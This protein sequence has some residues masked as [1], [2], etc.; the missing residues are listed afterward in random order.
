MSG[1]KRLMRQPD[2][3]M[4]GGVCTGLGDY[5]DMDYTIIRLI[6]VLLFLFGG[7]GGLAY[8]IAWIVIPER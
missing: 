7:I 8:I 4:I 1:T 6:W 5:F 2:G 3:K